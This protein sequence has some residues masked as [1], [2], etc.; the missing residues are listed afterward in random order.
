MPMINIETI[1]WTGDTAPLLQS[2]DSD[3]NRIGGDHYILQFTMITIDKQR[4][5]CL[6]SIDISL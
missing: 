4:T 1:I 6:L 3:R 2:S 5:T